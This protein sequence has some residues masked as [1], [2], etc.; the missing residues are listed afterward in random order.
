[1]DI[2][3]IS[4]AIQFAQRTYPLGEELKKMGHNVHYSTYSKECKEFF[5]KR[6]VEARYIL[7]ELLGYKVDKKLDYLSKKYEIKYEVPSMNLLLLGDV[8]YSKKGRKKALEGLVQHFMYWENFFSK[9]KI[10]V[11]IGGTERFVNE[12]PREVIKKFGG[13][14]LSYKIQPIP[15]TFALSKDPQGVISSL[16][17][18]W[19]KYKNKKLS[20]EERNN[21]EKYIKSA[22]DKKK[23]VY[24]IFDPPKINK[25][26]IS[27][28]LKRLYLNLTKE[29]MKNPYADLFKI[30]KNLGTRA[31]R[32]HISRFYYEK[33]KENEDYVY[34]PISREHDAALLVRA[35]QFVNQVAF[36]ENLA[37]HLPINYKLYVKEHPSGLGETK[38]KQLRALKKLPNVRILDPSLSGHNLVANSKA[39]AT[40]NSNTGWEA[41]LYKKP[42][43]T[44][45]KTFY[46]CSGL[47]YPIKNFYDFNSIFNKAI[48]S[49]FDYELFL[50]FINC[51]FKSVKKGNAVF[52]G[53]LEKTLYDK[54]NIK[55]LAKGIVQTA[56]EIKKEESN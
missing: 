38:I 44:F 47:V 5:K 24:L 36:L 46:N 12:V 1:M 13:F 34:Y 6:G 40:I 21:A 20:K 29:R 15:N 30:A 25:K 19:K 27:I 26:G 22:V 52:V 31:I 18:N 3:F 32:K 9:Q 28:F 8:N 45:G 2:L 4:N 10:D 51:V 39:V 41:L 14:Q 37:N 50:K 42:I 35:P 7:D 54:E 56:E 53:S 55:N 23:G 16:E 48:N 33:P 43:L 11:V 17:L 49:K